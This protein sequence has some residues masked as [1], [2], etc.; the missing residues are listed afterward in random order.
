MNFMF[1]KLLLFYLF[2]TFPSVQSALKDIQIARFLA[3]FIPC[4]QAL[5]RKVCAPDEN[6]MNMNFWRNKYRF[7]HHNFIGRMLY[8]HIFVDFVFIIMPLT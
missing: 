6:K 4:V 5:K 2:V 7:V 8:L 1:F 3:I